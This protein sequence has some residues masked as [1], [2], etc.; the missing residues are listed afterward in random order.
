MSRPLLYLFPDQVMLYVCPTPIGNLGDI[1]LRVLE[2]LRTVDLVAAEDTRRTGKLLAHFDIEKPQL[3]FY[4]HNETRRVPE[5]LDLL[6]E[7]KNVAL[8]SD[9]GMP[10]ICDPGYRLIGSVL[11]AGLDVEVLPGPS[12]LETALVASGFATD[13][14]VFTG[15]LPRKKGE[16]DEALRAIASENRTCISYEAPHRLAATLAA[17]AGIIGPRRMAVCRELTK[18]FEE[19]RRGTAAELATAFSEKVKG[20]IVLV[21]DAQEVSRADDDDERELAAA[22][23]E[24]LAAGLSPRH[25]AKIAAS[26]SGAPKNRTYDLALQIKKNS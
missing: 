25:A 20:E 5:I 17:A 6:R 21:F 16:R 14:F 2:T 1:T 9:A 26:L 15:Y 24:L 7:G 12:A 23:T 8:V 11:D 18:K 4:E 3:S 10:G 13:A 22:L 19:I